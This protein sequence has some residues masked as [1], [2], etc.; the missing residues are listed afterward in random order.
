MKNII[1]DL[2]VLLIL[3]FVPGLV[4]LDEYR[5]EYKLEHGSTGCVRVCVKAGDN[6]WSL[7]T[8]HAPTWAQLNRYVY[9]VAKLNCIENKFIQPGDM[10]IIPLYEE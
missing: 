1:Y 3:L 10:I 9:H 6:L 7:A 2:L 8:P 4:I 5:V